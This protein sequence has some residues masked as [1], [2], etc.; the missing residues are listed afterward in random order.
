MLLVLQKA[1][2]EKVINLSRAIELTTSAPAR[3]IP[4][5]APRRG[6]IHTDMVADICIV[7][8]DDI[9]QV[10]YVIIGGKIVVDDGRIV[11]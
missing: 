8:R 3:I 1:I 7:D 5:V 10:K 6:L 4:K 2:E 9:S 11:R